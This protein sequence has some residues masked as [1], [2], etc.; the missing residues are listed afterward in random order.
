MENSN[1]TELG[2]ANYTPL[3]FAQHTVL[4]TGANRGIGLAIVKA[5][6]ATPIKKVYATARNLAAM[7]DLQ[8][9]RLE[10]LQLDITDDASVTRAANIASDVSL[11]INNAGIVAAGAFTETELATL[12]TDMQTNYFGTLRAIQAFLPALRANTQA[13]ASAAI[14]NV[15]SIGALANLPSIGG[16]CASKAAIFS[17]SQG[18]RIE[19]AK[20]PIQV[21][22]INPGPID[23]DMTKDFDGDKTDS[24]VAAEAILQGLREGQQD[25]FPDP[26]SQAMFAA[27]QSNYKS[28]EAI[29]AQMS[30]A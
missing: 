26:A 4:V 23:T 28:L 19:L 25:I 24:A 3:D 30:E 15:T 1:T 18:L 10:V 13:E 5:L 7:P 14:A 22:T 6:L 9:A 2:N 20:A 29:F 12:N 11:L 16:Y 17:A 8:D 27:W 21:H